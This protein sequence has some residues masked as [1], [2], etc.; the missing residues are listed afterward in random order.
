MDTDFR[1]FDEM[2]SSRFYGSND[3]KSGPVTVKIKGFESGQLKDKSGKESPAVFVKFDGT[4][5]VLIVKANVRKVLKKHYGTPE[6]AVGQ[7]LELY[8]DEDVEFGGETIGGLRV[9]KPATSQPAAT[10]F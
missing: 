7:P 3:V 9:R 8:F 2:S 4:E 10:P 6:Q 5:K 1:S